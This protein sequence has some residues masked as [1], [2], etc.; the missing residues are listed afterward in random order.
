[1]SVDHHL[2]SILLVAL[3]GA[4]GSVLRYLLSAWTFAQAVHWRFP[5]GT[6][7]VNI[8][9]CLMV[10]LLA[11]LMAK[12]QFLSPDARLFLITGIAGGFTTFSALGME[13]FH[14]LRRGDMLIAGSYV[15]SSVIVG[16]LCVWVGFVLISGRG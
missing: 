13:T 4:T 5:I 2:K 7:V 16:I 11:G 8:L 3:G 14:L 12:H 1:M 10:G 9:G 6:F 15:A